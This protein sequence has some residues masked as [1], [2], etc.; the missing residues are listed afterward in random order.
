MP[1][2]YVLEAGDVKC[3]CDV[4]QSLNWEFAC[5]SLYT[6]QT[7]TKATGTVDGMKLMMQFGKQLGFFNS[8]G[9]KITSMDVYIGGEQLRLSKP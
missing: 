9:D 3:A 4:Y 2:R 6:G 8:K 5:V 7:M 1:G